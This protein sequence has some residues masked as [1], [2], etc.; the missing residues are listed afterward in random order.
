MNVA[1]KDSKRHM[2]SQRLVNLIRYTLLIRFTNACVFLRQKHR[3]KEKTN[4][5]QNK[6]QKSIYA[7][8]TVLLTVPCFVLYC[9]SLENG[10]ILNINLKE[11][12]IYIPIEYVLAYVSAVFIGNPLAMKIAFK[13]VSPKDTDPVIVKTVIVCA[14]ACVMCPWMSFLATILYKGI[15]PGLIYHAANFT[16]ANFFVYFIPNFLQAFVQNLPFALLSQLFFIQP[17][18]R[19]IFGFIFNRNTN[20]EA[21]GEVELNNQGLAEA[22]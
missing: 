17:A 4:M 11:V 1:N 16:L 15:F 8:I 22:N 12:L 13:T 5:P 18:T 7:L 14:T 3:R 10:G 21:N 9:T 19:K 6:F 2:W 20:K